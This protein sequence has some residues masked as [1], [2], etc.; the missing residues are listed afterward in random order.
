MK[1]RKLLFWYVWSAFVL[2][3]AITS[4]IFAQVFSSVIAVMAVIT[5]TMIYIR[6]EHL[7]E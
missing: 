2:S 1:L 5:S 3:F 6:G 7:D 4:S